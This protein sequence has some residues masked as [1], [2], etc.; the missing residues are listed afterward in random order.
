MKSQV[1]KA[2]GRYFCENIH[3]KKWTPKGCLLRKVG[4]TCDNN[5]CYFNVSPM[6]GIYQCGCM[7]VH[8]DADGKCL[9]VKER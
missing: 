4:L 3:C 2:F 7:D 8:L 9:G 5:S 1:K 6:A